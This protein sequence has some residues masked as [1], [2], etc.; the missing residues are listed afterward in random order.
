VPPRPARRR[1]HDKRG[2]PLSD[3]HDYQ[4]MKPDV[5]VRCGSRHANH[6]RRVP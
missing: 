5:P 4:Q 1:D 3:V 2:I 6:S